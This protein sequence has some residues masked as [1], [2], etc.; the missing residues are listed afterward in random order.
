[1]D[2]KIEIDLGE[3]LNIIWSK[4]IKII[5]ITLFF[6]II[7]VLVNIYLIKPQYKSTVTVIVGQEN[8]EEGDN[9]SSDSVVMYQKLIKTYSE[10]ASSE[11]VAKKTMKDIGLS[12]S[13]KQVETFR[14]SI[15]I[16]PKSDTQ[17]IEIS[18]INRDAAQSTNIVN[19]LTENFIEESN[20]LLP[21]GDIK[22]LDSASVP[23]KPIKPNK[24]LNTLIVS[25]IIFVTI[26]TIFVIFE[27]KN[28]TIK[29]EDD[30]E[31]YLELNVIGS[32][33]ED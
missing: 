20:S 2:D 21:I 17:I 10:I 30:V 8:K 13:Y 9:Y 5:F 14:K 26:T 19:K 6:G 31:K 7:T 33:L 32:I 4:K 29:T 12:T 1:M 18:V 15:S 3:I 24:T 11:M 23:Q 16:E 25:I 28:K 22:I 27:L